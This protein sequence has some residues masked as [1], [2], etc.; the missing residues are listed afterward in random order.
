MNRD[1]CT[2]CCGAAAC[3]NGDLLHY[4]CDDGNGVNGD[5][6]TSVCLVELG[7]T[8]VHGAGIGSYSTC[9]SICGD[10]WIVGAEGCDDKN[11]VS[12]DGCSSACVVE[13]GWVCYSAPS[14]CY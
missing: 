1:I 8:C 11:T 10:G 7:W 13:N 5:G 3:N 4:E 2:E 14:I 9:T 12:G 6:C